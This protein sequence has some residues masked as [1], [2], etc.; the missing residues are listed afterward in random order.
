MG[1]HR[2]FD[3]VFSWHDAAHVLVGIFAG[4]QPRQFG[5]FLTHSRPWG[6]LVETV[7]QRI[8]G[9][10]FSS[11]YIPPDSHNNR[12]AQHFD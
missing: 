6:A 1:A 11:V 5:T 2:D 9:A 12:R 4:R 8:A 3:N 10:G 7:N